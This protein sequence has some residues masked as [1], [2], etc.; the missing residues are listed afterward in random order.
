MKKLLV[1]MLVMSMASSVDA[2]L[3]IT[4]NGAT[5]ELTLNAGQIM[6]ISVWGDGESQTGEYMLGISKTSVGTGVLD[7]SYASVYY[8]GTDAYIIQSNIESFEL[9]KAPA[10]ALGLIDNV[11]G[12]E[13]KDA[14]SGELVSTIMFTAGPTGGFVGL[15]ILNPG[16]DTVLN[17]LAVSVIGV[18]EPMTIGLLCLGGL[19]L[20]R[21]K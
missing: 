13:S 19:Y 9:I 17:E 15:R 2:A 12:G 7:V 6:F 3:W 16:L 21:R 1:V 18:P 10:I 5:D 14:L 11:Q 4:V 8:P 20:R